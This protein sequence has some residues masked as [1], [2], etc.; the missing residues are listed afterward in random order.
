MPLNTV[1]KEGFIEFVKVL[2]PFYKVPCRNS[3]TT[4]VEEKYI[5]LSNKIKK[6]LSNIDALSLTTDVW[7]ETYNSESFLELTAHFFTK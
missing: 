7:T 2:N 4:L 1:E 5:V 6:D 3:T